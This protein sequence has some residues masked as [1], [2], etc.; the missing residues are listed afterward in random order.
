MH[1]GLTQRVIIMPYKPG[2]SMQ[3][4][5][6]TMYAYNRISK[7]VL[8]TLSLLTLSVNAEER[9]GKYQLAKKVGTEVIQ[10]WKYLYFS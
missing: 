9:V 6:Y 3:R 8:V 10:T 7:T 1:E 4:G 5:R 2:R